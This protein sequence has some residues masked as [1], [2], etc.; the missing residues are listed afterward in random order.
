MGCS[1][2]LGH[3]GQT[4]RECRTESEVRLDEGLMRAA[5]AASVMRTSCCDLWRSRG[6]HRDGCPGAKEPGP[7]Q[8]WTASRAFGYE[9]NPLHDSLHTRI[10]QLQEMLADIGDEKDVHERDRRVHEARTLLE[11]IRKDVIK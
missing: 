10:N 8:D 9:Y 6:Y 2:C 7:S 11:M 4:C 5:R 3:G 1:K